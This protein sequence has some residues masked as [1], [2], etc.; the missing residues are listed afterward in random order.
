MNKRTLLLFLILTTVSFKSMAN[1]CFVEGIGI[2]TK[3]KINI[4]KKVIKISSVKGE[5]IL[6]YAYRELQDISSSPYKHFFKLFSKKLR[7]KSA[8]LFKF[9]NITTEYSLMS[10]TE[11]FE[12][13]T[14]GHREYILVKKGVIL[15]R[16]SQEFDNSNY[17]ANKSSIVE[18]KSLAMSLL[19][20]A[21][22]VN[23]QSIYKEM[24]QKLEESK[25][26]FKNCFSPNALLCYNLASPNEIGINSKKTI[27]VSE[28]LSFYK[29]PMKV[30][31]QSIIHEVG[32]MVLDGE[33]EVT[34]LEH[35]IMVDSVGQ[36][37]RFNGYTVQYMDLF[38]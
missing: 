13:S 21:D 34:K 36:I 32:H 26:V 7:S 25:T 6:N 10:D 12:L 9:N 5:I 20:K 35:Q 38:L 8:Q 4:K 31:A 17:R 18:A 3:L 11:I 14:K 23:A 30:L 28:T 22:R 24:L 37:Y 19:R 16:C 33:I 29:N 1:V 15:N 27:S 2:E